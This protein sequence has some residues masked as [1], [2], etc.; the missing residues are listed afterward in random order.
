MGEE[1]VNQDRGIGS[2]TLEATFWSDLECAVQR[3]VQL[4]RDNPNP[5]FAPLVPEP[6]HPHRSRILAALIAID[7]EHCWQAGRFDEA[8]SLRASRPA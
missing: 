7:L 6:S 5:D 4:W 2:E 8:E 3:L 1:E